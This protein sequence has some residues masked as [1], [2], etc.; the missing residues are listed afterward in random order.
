MPEFLQVLELRGF[1]VR[2][3]RRL[4][5]R[6]SFWVLVGLRI[7]QSFGSSDVPA[8]VGLGRIARMSS[9]RMNLVMICLELTTW[10]SLM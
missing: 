2:D 3:D 1:R 9:G 4:A 10:T 7:G 8:T 6:I 5:R